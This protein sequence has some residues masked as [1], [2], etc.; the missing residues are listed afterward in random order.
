MIDAQREHGTRVEE[1]AKLVADDFD[2]RE[3]AHHLDTAGGT[4]RAG[5]D[6]THGEEYD[7]REVR[8]R[9]E[10]FGRETGGA[11]HSD[12][13]KQ[14]FAE[15]MFAKVAGFEPFAE[16]DDRHRQHTRSK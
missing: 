8:P 16:R 12:H 6:H 5:T 10:V 13:I 11:H 9:E 7:P 14:R 3:Y 2:G 1:T 4:S 15:G